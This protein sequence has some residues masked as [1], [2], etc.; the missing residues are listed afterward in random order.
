MHILLA[1][2]PNYIDAY[3]KWGADLVLSGHNHGGIARIPGICGVLST[4][5]VIFPKYTKGYYSDGDTKL[6]VSA[7]IGGHT[8]KARFFNPPEILII[9]LKK[10]K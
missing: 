1:H 10:D 4:E 3:S 8:I 7:G 5:A 9:T 2:S 6:L